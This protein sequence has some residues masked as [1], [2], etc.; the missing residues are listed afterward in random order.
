MTAESVPEVQAAGGTTS[1]CRAPRA[2]S[3]AVVEP[4]D[5]Q[6]TSI[7]PGGGVCMRLELA[8]GRVRRWYLRTFRPGY[9]ARMRRLR[10]GDDRGCP[11]DVLDPRDLKFYRNQG[12]CSW[13]P[14]DDPFA[15]RDRLPLVRAGL[16]E[17]LI[18]GGGA[19]LLAAV[20]VWWWW[21]AAVPLA[22]WG[23]LILWFFRNPKRTAPSESG[24]IVSPADGKV[25]AIDELASHEYVGGPAVKIAVFLSVFNVHVNRAPAAACVVGLTYAR[26]KF[27]GAMRRRASKE[28][29]RMTI[30]L[31]E[32][33]PPHRR[34]VVV[35]IAGAVARRIV[36]WVAPGENLSRGQALGMI[37]LGSRTELILPRQPGLI[38]EARLGQSVRAGTTVLARYVEPALET[39]TRRCSASGSG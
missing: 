20:I 16:A 29:E 31:E 32:T 28:N 33:S 13:R 34:L 23:A 4:L 7:Q 18:L 36:C 5:P 12:T 6:I 3:Q 22:V 38:L 27:L 24:M 14:E 2:P 37:K 26:G 35:Q 30:R 8:W 39:P 15:W 19:W 10:L 17:L 25:V 9:V 21:P 1:G 11:H